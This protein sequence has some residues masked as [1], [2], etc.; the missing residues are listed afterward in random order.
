MPYRHLLEEDN[1]E[2]ERGPMPR[3]TDAPLQERDVQGTA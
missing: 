3:E 2:S 1:R